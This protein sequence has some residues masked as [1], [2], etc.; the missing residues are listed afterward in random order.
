[1][2]TTATDAV[3]RGKI[4]SIQGSVSPSEK[5]LDYGTN[6][7]HFGR[8]IRPDGYARVKGPCGDTDEIFLRIREGK[9]K[10]AKFITDGSLFAKAACNAVA[11]LAI[12]KALHQCLRIDQDSILKHLEGIPYS[13]I[14]CALL[15]ATALSTAVR[16][17]VLDGTK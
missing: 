3:C 14:H 9:I 11:H 17:Y 15:A 5:T 13:H 8:M 16:N 10:E 7:A 4:V 12:G 6:P 2:N 1:M